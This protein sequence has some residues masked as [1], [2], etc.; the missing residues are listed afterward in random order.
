ME[1]SNIKPGENVKRSGQYVEAG[2][3]GGKGS[4]EVTLV[5]DKKAPPTSKPGRTYVL[6]D[7]TKHKRNR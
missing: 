1:K 4:T 5:K 2:P 3:R 7:P 6:V